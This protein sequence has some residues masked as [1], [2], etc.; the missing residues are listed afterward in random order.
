MIWTIIIIAVVVVIA[1]IVKRSNSEKQLNS[2]N[3]TNTI[4]NNIY[5]DI[6][7]YDE[8]VLNITIKHDNGI[9]E[10]K[11]FDNIPTKGNY[12][13]I[14]VNCGYTEIDVLLKFLF[15]KIYMS[16]LKYELFSITA[17]ELNNYIKRLH[18]NIQHLT[19]NSSVKLSPEQDVMTQLI[20]D[21][22]LP[23]ATNL[24]HKECR[25]HLQSA[26]Y[27]RIFDLFDLNRDL[28]M[29][30]G[31]LDKVPQNELKPIYPTSEIEK[32]EFTILD[33]DE[34]KIKSDFYWE[35]LFRNSYDIV[36]KMFP[37]QQEFKRFYE[38]QG[39]NW[40]RMSEVQDNI[41]E[42]IEDIVRFNNCLQKTINVCEEKANRIIDDTY[43]QVLLKSGINQKQYYKE[44]DKIKQM[45]SSHLSPIVAASCDATVKKVAAII[46]QKQDILDKN[47][48]DIVKYQD[49]LEIIKK[50]MVEE[51]QLQRIKELNK[52]IGK[53]DNE[54][55]IVKKEE[56]N[57]E[58][59][60]MIEDINRMEI[61]VNERRNL[62]IQFGEIEI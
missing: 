30:Y 52:E 49:M 54:A 38:K 40:L 25:I 20:N 17:E 7:G 44:C 55:D 36:W 27:K 53:F 13:D 31:G 43:G 8:N 16:Y 15:P 6:T 34:G 18:I 21:Y 56:K 4:P 35:V 51:N 48:A 50:Q 1:I 26:M 39:E 24:M 32:L 11:L 47:N 10:K 3:K 60:N 23:G 57:L 22:I 37:I 9:F 42:K 61:E 28:V 41:N 2:A 14:D 29:R 59:E 46:K 12:E 62:E 5:K 45:Y 33:M 19:S 58:F